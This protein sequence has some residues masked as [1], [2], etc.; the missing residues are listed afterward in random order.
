MN[1]LLAFGA[2]K[3]QQVLFDW[4]AQPVVDKI[5]THHH[6]VPDFYANGKTQHALGLIYR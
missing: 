6:Y 5:D 4:P 2:L 1:R 3:M